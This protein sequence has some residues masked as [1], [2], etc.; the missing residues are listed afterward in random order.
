MAENTPLSSN[1]VVDNLRG[2]LCDVPLGRHSSTVREAIAE[3]ER[4]RVV[5]LKHGTHAAG[6]SN[7]RNV[8][9]CSCGLWEALRG[10]VET[11]G[12]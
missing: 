7:R 3:I 1:L 8:G 4:L 11:T 6:C 10:A 5:L 2:L 12:S 9:E